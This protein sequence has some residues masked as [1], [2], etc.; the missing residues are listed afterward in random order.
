MV[1]LAIIDLLFNW[2]PEGGARTDIREVALRLSE[3][4]QVALFCPDYRIGFP[5]GSISQDPGIVVRKVPFKD[6]EFQLFTLPRRFRAAIDEFNPDLVYIADGWHFKPYVVD[7]MRGYRRIMRFYAYETLCPRSHGHFIDF[8]THLCRRNWLDGWRDFVP[9]L[10]CAHEWLYDNPFVN[11]F[12]IPFMRSLAFLPSYPHLVRRVLESV[13]TIICYNEFIAGKLRRYNQDVR[14]TPSGI[15]ASNFASSNTKEEQWPKRV[16]M[17]GRKGD[18]LKGFE[19][20]FKAIAPLV[21]RGEQVR[22]FVTEGP[23]REE[24]FMTYTGWLDQKGLADLYR[25]MDICV[26]PSMWQEPFGIVALEAMACEKPII[27]S[28][29]GGLQHIVTD[30]VDGFVVEPFDPLQLRD[31]LQ[32]LINDPE[33]C[34]SMG[35]AGRKKVLEKYQW[36]TIVEQY[37][38]PLMVGG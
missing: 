11:H 34:R 22:L 20:L 3:R 37:Y 12:R 36:S 31:R 38:E 10:C 5:R 28:R 27:V 25:Q 33:L 18:P 4:H 35:K 23:A 13:D 2:P 26:V 16:L 30:G 32:T 9:C 17:A 15:D 19:V 14:I 24:G 1:K 7:A 8:T 6:Y 29:V 21:Q